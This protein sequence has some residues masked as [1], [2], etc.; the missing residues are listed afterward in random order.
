MYKIQFKD[1]H[2]VLVTIYFTHSLS[3]R[4]TPEGHTCI[5]DG[6]HNNGGWIIPKSKYTHKEI[7]EIIDDVISG[8]DYKWKN[9]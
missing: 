4:E 3:V 8:V 9:E 1:I 5:L 2:N 7:L 6:L